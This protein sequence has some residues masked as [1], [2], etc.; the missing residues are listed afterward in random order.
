MSFTSHFSC[1]WPDPSNFACR[2]PS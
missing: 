1:E 2:Q